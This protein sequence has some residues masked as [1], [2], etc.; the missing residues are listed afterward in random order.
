MKIAIITEY[1]PQSEN[2]ETRG[3]VEIRSFYVARELAKKHNVTVI[4]SQELSTPKEQTFDG[5]KIIRCGKS[6]KH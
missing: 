4:C 6:K 5:I 1:F 3:G 2:C